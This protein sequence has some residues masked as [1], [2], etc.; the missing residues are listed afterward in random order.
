M[1]NVGGEKVFPSEVE[2]MMLAHPKIKDLVVVGIPHEIKGEAPKAFIQLK[3][4]ETATVEE[5]PEFL[6]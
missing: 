2:D 1:I 3:E 6:C 4:N 5:I